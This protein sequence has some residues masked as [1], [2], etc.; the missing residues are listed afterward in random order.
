MAKRDIEGDVFMHCVD[1]CRLMKAQGFS[2]DTLA[3][4]MAECILAAAGVPLD[5]AIAMFGEDKN[6]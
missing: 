3:V 1:M 6:G 2:N 5:E 4:S